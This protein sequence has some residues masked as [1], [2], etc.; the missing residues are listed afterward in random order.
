VDD[1][2]AVIEVFAEQA[3]RHALLEV[4]M[5]RGDKAQHRGLTAHPV[6]LPFG[7][8][9]RHFIVGVHQ[10]DRLALQA[11]APQLID[12]LWDARHLG[13]GFACVEPDRGALVGR[14]RPARR[15][16][17]AGILSMQG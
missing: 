9:H 8:R 5:C 13:R 1:V 15:V 10:E 6:K 16:G 7:C 2:D 11:A 3:A 12:Q 14:L 17:D 4:L